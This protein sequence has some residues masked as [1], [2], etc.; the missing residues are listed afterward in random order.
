MRKIGIGLSA[1]LILRRSQAGHCPRCKR[2]RVPA[3]SRVRLLRG[4]RISWLRK[5]RHAE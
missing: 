2:S 1:L 5:L 4:C 3:V